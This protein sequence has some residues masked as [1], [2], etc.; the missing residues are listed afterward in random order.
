MIKET[1]GSE[2]QWSFC[3][4][5]LINASVHQLVP[6]A[7]PPSPPRASV[8]ISV[9]VSAAPSPFISSNLP[10][11]PPLP[12]SSISASPRH[13][14]LRVWSRPQHAHRA[15]LGLLFCLGPFSVLGSQMPIHSVTISFFFGVWEALT[16]DLRITQKL[17]DLCDSQLHHHYTFDKLVFVT[18]IILNQST[19]VHFLTFEQENDEPCQLTFPAQVNMN[20]YIFNPFKRG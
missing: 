14:H 7:R 5:V 13:R 12:K 8:P 20:R 11:P 17:W 2:V 16:L 15:R 18:Y 1:K 10:P 3:C 6:S 19:K 9:F 4:W